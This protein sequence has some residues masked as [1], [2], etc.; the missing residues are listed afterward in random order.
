MKLRIYI[1]IIIVVVCLFS[2]ERRDNSVYNPSLL[3]LENSL[4]IMP[5]KTL[6]ENLIQI[7]HPLG[8]PIRPFTIFC[9]S[10][11]RY[12]P[13]IVSKFLQTSRIFRYPISQKNEILYVCANYTII[14]EGYI[15][16]IML[17]FGPIVVIIKL[18][19]SQ[20]KISSGFSTSRQEKPVFIILK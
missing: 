3:L 2:C 12:F 8:R 7:R 17:F 6:R 9:C 5:E 14:Q 20:E 15:S 16:I 19:S 4:E 10:R 1:I 18:K 11:L 13:L